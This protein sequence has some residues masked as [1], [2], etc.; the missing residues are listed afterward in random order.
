MDIKQ[1]PDRPITKLYT[2]SKSGIQK[3]AVELAPRL[4]EKDA[5]G[6]ERIL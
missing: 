5:S 3:S 1:L 4:S 6:S 2:T